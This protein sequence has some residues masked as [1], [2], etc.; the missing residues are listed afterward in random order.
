MQL[1]W[2]IYNWENSEEFEAWEFSGTCPLIMWLH[3]SVFI[4][5][6]KHC[7]WEFIYVVNNWQGRLFLFWSWVRTKCFLGLVKLEFW[8]PDVLRSWTMLQSV[9]NVGCEHSLPAGILFQLVL[10]PLHFK[11]FVEVLSI[12]SARFH[13]KCKILFFLSL[14][15][16]SLYI[17][18]IFISFWIWCLKDSL[19]EHCML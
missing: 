13:Q 5:L 12:A 14:Y 1:W 9:F 2:K 3:S 17:N 10:L 11:L 19:L 8:T 4:M 16:D 15:C 18:L 6:T 7:E